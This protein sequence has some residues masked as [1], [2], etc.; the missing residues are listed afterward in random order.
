MLSVLLRYSLILAA[1]K[2]P[3]FLAVTGW[4]HLLQMAMEAKAAEGRLGRGVP[5]AEM[6]V[7]S[8]SSL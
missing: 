2:I 6:F 4:D 3:M 8:L 7:R 1:I 5:G